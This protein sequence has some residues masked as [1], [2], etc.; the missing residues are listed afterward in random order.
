MN[1]ILP[2]E[3]LNMIYKNKN[4]SEIS[5]EEKK[6]EELNLDDRMHLMSKQIDNNVIHNIYDGLC[7][8]KNLI[9]QDN[10]VEIN[11]YVFNDVEL[12]HDYYLNENNSLFDKLN[13]CHTKIG[14]LLLKNI[15]LKP[16]YDQKILLS[17]QNYL[18]K[19]NNIKDQ[20]IPIMKNI[21]SIENDLIWFWNDGNMKHIDLMK[22]MIYCN[23]DIIPFFNVC[24]ALN[25]NEKALLITNIYKI[26]ISP[27]LTCLTPIISL[28]VPLILMLYF[29]KKVGNALSW[30][31]IIINYFKTLWNNDTMKFLIQNPTK[32]NLASLATKGLYLFMYFQNIYYSIQSSSNTNKIINIIHE[33]LNKMTLYI[34]YSKQIEEICT[35]NGLDNIS[36]YLHYNNVK[37]DNELYYLNYFCFP[38]F[39]KEPGLFTNKGKILK[40]FSD[41]RHNKDILLNVFHYN[42]IIDVLLSTNNLLNNSSESHPYTKTSY[43]DS[44]VPKI[45]I[46]NIWHPFLDKNVTNNVV[47]N[48]IKIHKNLL[49]TGPNAAGKSTFIKS[50]IINIILAQTIG[51]NSCTKFEL[52][53]FHLL[54]TFLNIPDIKGTSSLFEAEMIRSKDYIEKISNIEEDKFSF[55]VLDE[56]FSSTNYVEGF[57]GAY[58]ILKKLST[59]KNALFIVTTHYTDL[60]ILEKDTNG[61]IK[62]YKFEIS[63]NENKD[64]IFNYLIKEGISRQYIALEL[65]EKNGF[66]DD[67]I[68]DAKNICSKIK[69]NKIHFIKNNDNKKKK[70]GKK[71]KI[72]SKNEKNKD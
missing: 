50:V 23:W 36:S 11:D 52:S 58:S 12:L 1:T 15:L 20:L 9:Y 30:K 46:E 35:K 43:L 63:Y 44:T 48:N 39:E 33:K 72:I 18:N 27:I 68:I 8:R 26:V 40:T 70:K 16:V 34:K 67:I 7:K 22:D 71:E 61:K 64:I 28:L 38:V 53:P 10:L 3:L 49:I 66:S 69:N 47:K 65:L 13:K 42:G 4:T 37:E 17:R 59:Y 24:D 29:N 14:S 54:E 2:N 62:N 45:N 51:I 31:Q 60:E 55:I 56:I 5:P 25:K 57:S 32:A 21:K 6:E 41:F 19:I